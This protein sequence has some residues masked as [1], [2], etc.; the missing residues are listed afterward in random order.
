[1]Y[2]TE[3]GTS[4]GDTNNY[5][6][7]HGRDPNGRRL[8]PVLLKDVAGLVPGA[9]QGKG[10]GN[11]F[12]NDLT[13]ATVLIHVVDASGTADASGNKTVA[14]EAEMGGGDLSNPLDDLAWIRNELVEWIYS[15]LMAKWDTVIRKGR[16]KLA[17]M[18]SGYGQRESMV[19][20][21]FL[22]LENFLEVQYHRDRALDQTSTWNECDVHRLVSLFLGV[23]FPM[24]LCLNKCDLPTADRFVEQIEN[25]LPIHGAYRGTRMS[26][27]EEMNFVRVNMTGTKANDTV[28]TSPPI[29]V[30][31]CLTSAME[32][33]EPIL[34]FPVSDMITF[35]PMSGLNKTAVGDPSLP[36]RGMVQ[37]ITAAGGFAPT[38]WD[39]DEESYVLPSKSKD[40]VAAG[41]TAIT[42]GKLRDTLLMKPG[43]TVEDVFNTLKRLGALGGE[44]VRAEASSGRIGDKP[45]PVPK[46]ELVSRRTCVIKIMSTKRTAWQH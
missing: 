32:L 34:V 41:V 5:G 30:W 24:A 43:S 2:E 40:R 15:N 3:I 26:V 4:S 36:S 37:C 31:Q 45:K 7:T 13:D 35:A 27:R 28:K 9:Y 6:S 1:L 33:R 42:H 21:I 25:S 19:E 12:L 44:F 11:Q 16:T 10:R 38:C 8:I 46:Q 17:G 23:R 22:A 14:D 20:D 18:F 29:G 39:A